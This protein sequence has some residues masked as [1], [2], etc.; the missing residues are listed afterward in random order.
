MDIIRRKKPGI[1]LNIAPLIDI[2]FL[3]LIFFMLS[4][5]FITDA[6]IKV[7]LPQ[8]SAAK[9]CGSDNIVIAITKDNRLYLNE[10]EVSLESLPE[11]L[12]GVL[13][14]DL[15]RVII[16]AD[17]KVGLGLAVKVMDIA[18]QADAESLVISAEP[19]YSYGKESR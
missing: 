1:N 2:I 4:A 5:H 8:S 17:E 18:E 7:T 13:K 6:G 14:S 15:S 16:K 3:L 12:G 19:E 11:E 10:R 9:A